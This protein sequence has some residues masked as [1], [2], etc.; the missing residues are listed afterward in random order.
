MS[1][2][3]TLGVHLLAELDGC[4]SLP[5]EAGVCA[6]LTSA[7]AAG[8]AQLLSVHAHPFP[9]GGVAAVALLAESHLSIHTWPEHAYAAVDVFMCGAAARPDDALQAIV[10]ALGPGAVR[11]QRIG[12][13]RRPSTPPP[14]R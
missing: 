7:A 8:R 5:D 4:A 3:L 14:V 12:R 13:E 1:A 2:D 10:D 9:G 11:T 6:V